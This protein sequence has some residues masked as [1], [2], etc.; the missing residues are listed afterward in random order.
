[1]RSLSTPRS[2]DLVPTRLLYESMIA[3]GPGLRSWTTL[4]QVLLIMHGALWGI[5][6]FLGIA[7]ATRQGGIARV[8]QCLNIGIGSKV[9]AK[10]CVVASDLVVHI[11]FCLVLNNPMAF[12]RLYDDTNMAKPTSTIFSSS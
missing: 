9:W 11:F 12:T 3:M 1:M 10:F 8:S 6:L 7:P 2:T 4:L 5:I